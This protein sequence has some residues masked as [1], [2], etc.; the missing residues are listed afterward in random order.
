VVLEILLEGRIL[1][2]GEAHAKG[3][4]TRVVPSESRGGNLR[5]GA[6][7]RGRRAARC[8]L[9]QAVRAAADAA[10]GGR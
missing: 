1:D 2:A 9:A 4:V 7:H 8:A 10:C 3:L 6:A 5:D